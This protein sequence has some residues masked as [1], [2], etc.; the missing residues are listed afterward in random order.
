[1]T[2]E[3]WK[4]NENLIISAGKGFTRSLSR[5]T[6]MASRKMTTFLAMNFLQE[7]HE[8]KKERETFTDQEL[9]QVHAKSKVGGGL[10]VL[11]KKKSRYNF[12]PP[13]GH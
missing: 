13:P 6:S 10:N 5:K 12:F 4:L 3:Y 11:T 9:F 8:T 7:I 1:M 2:L